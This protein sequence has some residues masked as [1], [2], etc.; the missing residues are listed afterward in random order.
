MSAAAGMWEALRKVEQRFAELTEMLG[1]SEVVGDPRKL[2]DLS[3]ERAR[4]EETIR[5]LAEYRSA[6]RTLADD[7]R[8]AALGDE[9]LAEL[10]GAELPELRERLGRLEGALKRLLLPRDPDDD[11]NVIVEIRAGTGGTR[12]RSSPAT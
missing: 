5:T 8:A 10:A 3:R 2:R 1:S 11:K 12:P 9:E 7:E 4:L 6:E